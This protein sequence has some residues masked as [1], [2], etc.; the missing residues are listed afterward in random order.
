MF[1]G[2]AA[3]RVLVPRRDGG[4]VARHYTHRT[5]SIPTFIHIHTHQN[6]TQVFLVGQIR[7]ARD[8]AVLYTEATCLFVTSTNKLL[9]RKSALNI[10]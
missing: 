9:R 7:D 1:G 4:A 2:R 3:V 8:D 6:H 10:G 5:A